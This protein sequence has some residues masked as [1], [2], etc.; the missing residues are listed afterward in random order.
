MT[1]CGRSSPYI[2]GSPCWRSRRRTGC[3][4]SCFD[5]SLRALPELTERE[6]DLLAEIVF[7]R[8][9]HQ[10]GLPLGPTD[11]TVRNYVSSILAKLHAR[12]RA[13]TGRPS[14]TCELSRRL[15]G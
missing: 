15:K 14:A 8:S 3:N 5:L 4:A 1:S 6:H 11:K 2:A 12:D 13:R 9:N 10:I 7:G